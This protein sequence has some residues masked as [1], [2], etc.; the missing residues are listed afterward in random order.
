MVMPVL[1]IIWVNI[2]ANEAHGDE[3]PEG[4]ATKDGG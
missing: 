1:M 2:T 3:A 4:I